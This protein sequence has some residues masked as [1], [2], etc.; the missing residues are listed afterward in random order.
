MSSITTADAINILSKVV[1]GIEKNAT[2]CS[3]DGLLNND[4][5]DEVV[6]HDLSKSSN[7]KGII[8]SIS[9]PGSHKCPF[10]Q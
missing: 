10:E 4:I 3:V 8:K 6:V 2:R 9:T 5:R 7:D 1:D